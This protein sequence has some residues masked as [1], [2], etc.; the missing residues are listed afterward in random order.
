M[1]YRLVVIG[2]PLLPMGP[3]ARHGVRQASAAQ[4]AAL[5]HRH[6]ET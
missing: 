5:P 1:E 3:F 4:K 2:L 6:L